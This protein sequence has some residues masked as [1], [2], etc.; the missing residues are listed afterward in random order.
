[1]KDFFVVVTEDFFGVFEE[2]AP[3]YPDEFKHNLHIVTDVDEF[4]L[5][6]YLT[7]AVG[8]NNLIRV[9]FDL[10]YSLGRIHKRI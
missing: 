7:K 4:Q 5:E 2:S 6:T 3:S 9:G 10:N 8:V 1:M